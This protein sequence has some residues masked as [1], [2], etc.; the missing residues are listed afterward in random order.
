MDLTH[1]IDELA[2]LVLGIADQHQHSDCACLRVA[3]WLPVIRLDMGEAVRVG[4]SSAKHNGRSH[5]LGILGAGLLYGS[6]SLD[7]QQSVLEAF[8]Q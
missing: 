1:L 2:S 4:P 5:L 7:A 6:H 8:E 3:P